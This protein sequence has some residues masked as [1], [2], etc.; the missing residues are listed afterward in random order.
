MADAGEGGQGGAPSWLFSFVDLAFLMLI[1]MTIL[2]NQNAG[3][4]DL[5]EIVVPR[6]GEETTQDLSASRGEAWQLRVH[7]PV[8]DAL[9]LLGPAFELVLVGAEPTSI[10][11]A[12]TPEAYAPPAPAKINRGELRDRLVALERETVTRPLLAPHEDSRSQDLL[13][14][15]SMIEELWPGQRRAVIAKRTPR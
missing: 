1:A 8:R 15:A 6:I 9:D 2:A 14:A 13:D 5:G 11:T 12:E 10:G 7:P 4:P 3:A